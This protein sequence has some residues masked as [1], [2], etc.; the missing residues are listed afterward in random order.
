[1]NWV[2]TAA[3]LSDQ[4]STLLQINGN[5]SAANVFRTAGTVGNAVSIVS[6]ISDAFN[7]AGTIQAALSSNGENLINDAGL[8]ALYLDAYNPVAQTYSQ[9]VSPI[10]SNGIDYLS[11]Q[12]FGQ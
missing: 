2:G 11:N 12:L 1:L 10:I 3:D 5:T 7:S 4:V 6:G 9:L 8:N